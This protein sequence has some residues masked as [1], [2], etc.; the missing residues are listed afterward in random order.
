MS[1]P[2]PEQRDPQLV[3]ALEQAI[4][5]HSKKHYNAGVHAGLTRALQLLLGN[6]TEEDK[7][8]YDSVLKE[9]A[10]ES[11]KSKGKSLDPKPRT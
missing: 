10:D 5:S 6:L 4:R 11:L 9:L 7:I 2:T 8:R 1:S 3:E